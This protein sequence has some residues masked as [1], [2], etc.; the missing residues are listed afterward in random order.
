[1]H[2]VSASVRLLRRAALVAW[3]CSLAATPV[4]GQ[5]SKPSNEQPRPVFRA[6]TRLVQVSV[7]VK[8]SRGKPVADLTAGD[9]RLYEDG[10]QQPI[11]FFSVESDRMTGKAPASTT[12]S[13]EFT[14]SLEERVGGGVTAILFDQLNTGWADQVFARDHLV[15][16]LGQVRREDRLGLY[17]LESST[18][19]VLHDF[20]NDASSLLR[21][22]ARYQGVT[23]NELA[24]SEAKP[25]ETGDREID[26]WLAEDGAM[27]AADAITIRVQSTTAALEAIG[28]HLAGVSGRKNLIWVSS[29]FP[30]L[31]WQEGTPRTVT[32]LVNRATRALNN[33]GIAVYPVS[34]RGL[35][36]AFAIP[37]GASKPVFTTV[38]TGAADIDTMLMLAN[39]TGGRAFFNTNDIG[40]AV[41]RAIDD[42]RVTYVLGYYPSHD[43]WD[44]RFREI[45]VT[46]RR[47]GVEVRHR[48]GY[49]AAPAEQPPV[50]TREE[51]LRNLSRSPL[52]ATGLDLTVQ[53]T[54]GEQ[55]PSAGVDL[56]LRIDPRGVTLQRQADRWAGAIDVMIVQALPG[57]TYVS[58]AYLTITLNLTAAQRDEAMQKGFT[59]TRRIALKEDAH[60]LR[61]VARDLPS[62][63]TG[64]LAIPAERLRAAARR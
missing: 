60:Q 27:M 22:L 56:A 20:T 38:S 4:S 19:R 48:R 50:E 15:K 43:T 3:F 28:N 16:F 47:S 25:L 63:A 24:A 23:S 33:A 10:S 9:F 35:I 6:S 31:Y 49:L 54:P 13:G 61:V 37:P 45:N 21:A 2:A 53:V 36:G 30:A 46:V 59:L 8:D 14:N 58:S 5:A 52:E 51:M 1:M 57:G 12:T 17:V 40:G 41:R 55:G 7:I 18:V 39:D 44:G 42:A 29:G 26:A 11:E 34:A 32:R 62:G 64:S